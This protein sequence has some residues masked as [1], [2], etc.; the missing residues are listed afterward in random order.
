VIR[1]TLTPHQQEKIHSFTQ[2]LSRDGFIVTQKEIEYCMLSC[3]HFKGS[4]QDFYRKLN[5]IR[6]VISRGEWQT[7]AGMILDAKEKLNSNFLSL[8]ARCRD[9]KA[10]VNHFQGLLKTANEA[11][12]ANIETILI[13]AY[14]KLNELERHLRDASAGDSY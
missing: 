6:I 4:G 10:E 12:R 7:P 3:E 14:K 1:E 8:Q 2:T 13:G 9:A 11:V 5:A